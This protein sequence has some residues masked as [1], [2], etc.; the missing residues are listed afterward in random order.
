LRV[1]IVEDHPLYRFALEQ[2]LVERLRWI[3]T[4]CSDAT[5]AMTHA[6]ATKFELSVIDVGLPDMD[7][8]ALAERMLTETDVAL[9]A[10]ISA[11]T[12]PH[13]VREAL[14]VGATG[15][16]SKQ[17]SPDAM[18]IALAAVAA[19][20]TYM[21]EQTQA[22]LAT[23]L[24]EPVPQPSTGL[25]EREWNVL[26]LASRGLGVAAMAT[27]LQVSASTVKSHLSALYTKL[28]AHNR[29]AAVAEAARRGLV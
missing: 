12:R 14:R 28:G 11:E 24:R 19:G 9:V 6:R 8:I 20:T 23:A 22:A 10:M 18:A 13:E 25:T 1:L 2:L 5:S 26:R 16:V 4:P 17:L 29:A 3:V 15:F 21:C 27:D 7:G